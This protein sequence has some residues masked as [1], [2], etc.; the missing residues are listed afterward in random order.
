[1]LLLLAAGT[2]FG[3]RGTGQRA[4]SRPGIH[5]IAVLPLDN[6]SRDEQQEYFADGITDAIIDQLA[7]VQGLMV[8]SRTST[9]Q[10][11]K[12]RKPLR[13]IARELDVDTV[14]EG[15]VLRSGNRVRVST[16]LID[17]ATE[18]HLLSRTFE[19][20]LEDI[21]QLQQ[22]VARALGEQIRSQLAAEDAGRLSHPAPVD[23][24]AYQDFMLGRFHW[25]KRTPDGYMKSIDYFQQAITREPKYAMAYVGLADS[26]FS[27]QNAELVPPL[28]FKAQERAAILKALALDESLAEAHTR[29]GTESELRARAS[30]AW[31]RSGDP[32]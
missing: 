30:V 19:Q 10:Y 29:G 18:K 6:L 32:R 4:A 15:T 24:E 9:M 16:Q 31:Q 22:D 21:F 8:I 17:A 2:W 14:V 28:R 3:G 20:D 25:F 11:K 7:R 1:V 23:R 13:D 5:R 27:L 12:A 26:Y